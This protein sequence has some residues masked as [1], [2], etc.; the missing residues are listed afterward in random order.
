MFTVDKVRNI[1]HRPRTIKGIHGNQVFKSTRLEF[2]QVFLHT[3]RLEL[4]S[5][6]C[7][8]FAIQFIG[9]RITDIHFINVERY[10]L[11]MLDIFYRLLNDRQSLQPK[12]VH[13]NQAGIFN[14]RTFILGNQ[15]F[16]SGFLIVR[17][18]YRNPICYI[19]PTYN[20]TARV[21]SRVADIPFQHLGIF[22]RIA[23]NRVG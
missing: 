20:S 3:G 21:H 6:D 22:N 16:L 8:S 4:E 9:S 1:I 7:P 12:E 23:Q 10:T 15:H 19:I 5:T 11:T 18:T 14:D 13:L 17:R 2:T